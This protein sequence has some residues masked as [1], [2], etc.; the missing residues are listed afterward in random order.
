MRNLFFIVAVA[1]AALASACSSGDKAPQADATGSSADSSGSSTSL[2]VDTKKGGFS[3]SD[4]SG[5]DKTSIDINSGDQ[6]AD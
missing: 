5:G 1:I 4:E 6:D 2:S 3:Y